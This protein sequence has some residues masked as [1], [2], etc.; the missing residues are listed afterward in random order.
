[1]IALRS[2]AKAIYTTDNIGHY[3]LAF[4][5][6]THFTSPIRRYPDTMVHRLLA[7]Y[8]DN[9]E[10]QNKDYYEAQCQHASEREQIAANAERDSIKYK[11]IEFMQDK[12]GNEYEGSISGLTEWG[13]YVEIKP[14]MIEGMVALR[15]VKSDFF[16]FDEQNYLIRGRRTGKVFRLGDAVKIRVKAAN[17]EQR[18]LDYE[19]VDTTTDNGSS[20]DGS[21][22]GSNHGSSHRSGNGSGKCSDNG[23]GS[24]SADGKGKK[25]PFYASVAHNDDQP[26]RKSSKDKGRP[27]KKFGPKSSRNEKKKA[28]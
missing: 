27:R 11:M 10:S 9:A 23:S 25:K 15:D 8:L 28:K 13:M 3:G 18:L 24:G 19:L 7:L 26:K 21:G 14:T 2:M 4:K 5:F 12:I 1:M 6:Y 22:N 20:S 16:E 17:L